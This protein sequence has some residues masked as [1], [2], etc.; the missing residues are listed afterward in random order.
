MIA[1]GP[2][3]KGDKTILIIAFPDSYV[4]SL[5]LAVYE[6]VFVIVTM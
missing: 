6:N 2:F 3:Q 1:V 5:V 4:L